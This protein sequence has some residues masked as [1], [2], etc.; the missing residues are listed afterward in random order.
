[1]TTKSHSVNIASKIPKNPPTPYT[2]IDWIQYRDAARQ[3]NQD[4]LAQLF[5]TGWSELEI[6]GIPPAS[7]AG[8]GIAWSLCDAE[9]TE[10][11]SDSLTVKRPSGAMLNYYRY[12]NATARLKLPY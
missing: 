8:G 3:I 7:R 1:M 4:H 2:A 12:P 6:F 5:N 9:I 11:T 10:I